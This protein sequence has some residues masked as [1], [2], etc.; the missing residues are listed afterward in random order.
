MSFLYRLVVL[1]KLNNLVKEWILELGESKVRILLYVL[2]KTAEAFL[3]LLK[4]I[5]L[6][7]MLKL[8]FYTFFLSIE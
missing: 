3:F 7:F 4:A 8:N 6:G 1:G 5:L 2:I